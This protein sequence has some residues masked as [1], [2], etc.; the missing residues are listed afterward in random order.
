LRSDWVMRVLPSW[1]RLEAF[2]KGLGIASVMWALAFLSQRTQHQGTLLVVHSSSHQTAL[3]CQYLHLG[4]P[5]LWETFT[6][7]ITQAWVFC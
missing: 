1:V 6:I 2:I 5:E 7:E 3:T 4:L